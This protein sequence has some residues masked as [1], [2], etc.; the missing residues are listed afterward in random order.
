MFKF[1]E[2]KIPSSVNLIDKR[3]FID[4]HSLKNVLFE[5]PS[6]IP[7]IK[8]D[9]FMNCPSLENYFQLKKG[10]KMILFDF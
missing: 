3:A 9:S 2:K 10:K 5:N 6:I 4:C 8:A 7:S 1:I